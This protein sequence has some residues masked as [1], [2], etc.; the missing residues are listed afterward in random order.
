MKIWA[1]VDNIDILSVNETG[2]KSVSNDILNSRVFRVFSSGIRKNYGGVALIVR[3]KLPVKKV[4]KL[5]KGDLVTIELFRKG[6]KNVLISSVYFN[7]SIKN[8]KIT[9]LQ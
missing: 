8:G 5:C 7:P 3:G 2:L 6:M 9:G 4:D 1:E